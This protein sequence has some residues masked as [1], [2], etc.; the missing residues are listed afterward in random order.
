M[1]LTRKVFT[2]Q[3]PLPIT[4]QI[5]FLKPKEKTEVGI[6]CTHCV[7]INEKAAQELS[8]FIFLNLPLTEMKAGESRKFRFLDVPNL[9]LRL[10]DFFIFIF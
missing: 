4:R 9:C 2:E 8:R 7:K 6:C 5:R 3:K 1:P 10:E